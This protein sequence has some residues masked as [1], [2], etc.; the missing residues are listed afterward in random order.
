[1]S[2]CHF[3]SKSWNVISPYYSLSE[4][5]LSVMPLVVSLVWSLPV[6]LILS[7]ST[8]FSCILLNV[9]FQL[10]WVLYMT[11]DNLVIRVFQAD[12]HQQFPWQL[13]SFLIQRK[14]RERSLLG[15]LHCLVILTRLI[16]WWL[17]VILEFQ[18]RRNLSCHLSDYLFDRSWLGLLCRIYLGRKIIPLLWI[19]H[20]QVV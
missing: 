3:H 16:F 5:S 17:W 4:Y 15:H 18:N 19:Y 2:Y 12:L 6:F 11:V 7:F 13:V 9:I 14:G 8:L 20:S 1:M 10:Y